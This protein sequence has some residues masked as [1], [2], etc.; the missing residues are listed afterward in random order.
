[1]HDIFSRRRIW[2]GAVLLVIA[3]GLAGCF[4]QDVGDEAQGTVVSQNVPSDTPSPPPAATDTFTPTEF[5]D[6]PVADEGTPDGI[7]VAQGEEEAAQ[8]QETT[9]PFVFTATAL[10][11]EIT[12]TAAFGLTQTAIAEGIGA[13]PTPTITPTLEFSPTPTPPPAGSACIHEVVRGENLFRLSLRYGVD[14]QELANANGIANINRIIEGQKLTIPGC[15]TTGVT[16]P[17][18]SIPS[19]GTGSDPGSPGGGFTHVVRQGETLFQL[20]M[21][22]NVPVQSIANANGIT[23]INRI[24][25]GQELIIPGA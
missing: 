24:L 19:D 16:P 21:Q 8:A 17:P 15:G 10:V 23:N 12:Q 13:T 6:Q 5:V 25:I 11:A 2:I 22:Y 9:D 4:Q 7:A 18:T 14:V 1:M 3:T 20:S